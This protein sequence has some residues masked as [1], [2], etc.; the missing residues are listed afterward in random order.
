VKAAQF[1]TAVLKQQPAAGQLFTLLYSFK[2]VLLQVEVLLVQ[3]N[4]QLKVKRSADTQRF[5]HLKIIT[6]SSDKYYST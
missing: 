1:S 6:R 5:C 3:N 4:Q 2:N